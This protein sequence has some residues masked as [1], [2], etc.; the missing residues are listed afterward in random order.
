MVSLKKGKPLRKLKLYIETST[1]NFSVS[2]QDA[3]Y[4]QK[5]VELFEAIKRGEFEAYT[6]DLVMQEINRTENAERLNELLDVVKELSLEEL[7]V[8]EEIEELA[9]KYVEAELLPENYF[10]D[11]LH[12]AIASYHEI[13]AIVTMN[14]EHMVKYKTKKGIPSVNL[15]AGYKSLEIISPAEVI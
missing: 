3:Y 7:S 10:D 11:A 2:K 5:T 13:D 9:K 15:L 4:R 12:I 14:F 8:N 1:I 6:S